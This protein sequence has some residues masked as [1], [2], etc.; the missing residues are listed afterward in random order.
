MWLFRAPCTC[1]RVT[2]C[3][4]LLG[5]NMKWSQVK[6][7]PA[8]LCRCLHVQYGCDCA[9][10]C[11]TACTVEL[12]SQAIW[13]QCTGVNNR[14]QRVASGVRG[15]RQNSEREEEVKWVGEDRQDYFMSFIGASRPTLLCLS[16]II[17]LLPSSTK[18]HA[19]VQIIKPQNLFS[20]Q[21]DRCGGMWG[22]ETEGKCMH[23]ERQ[24]KGRIR[25]WE[26]HMP[27]S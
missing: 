9:L 2:F 11:M 24:E 25:S 8:V 17:P 22:H 10:P 7:C 20:T 18:H 19:W 1:F 27:D 3:I 6:S 23:R 26:T 13:L 21:R 14:G 5:I 16:L 15:Q 4:M 12:Q